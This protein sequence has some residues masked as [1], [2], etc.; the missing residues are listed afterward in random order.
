MKNPIIENLQDQVKNPK[1]QEYLH[2]VLSSF[3]NGNFRSSIVMLYSTVVCDII[4]KLTEMADIYGDAKA[5]DILQ[6][7]KDKQEEN[8]YS[9]DWENVLLDE[10]MKSHRVLEPSDYNNVDALK[11][12]R[13]LC[14][15]PVLKESNDLYQPNKAIV[16]GHILN[17]LENVLVKPSIVLQDLFHTFIED[18][19][20]KKSTLGTGDDMISY[21]TSQYLNK[22]NGPEY[23]YKIFKPLWKIVMKCADPEADDNREV[24]TNLLYCIYERNSQSFAAF[25]EN[26]KEYFGSNAGI[27]ENPTLLINFFNSHPEVY[28][29]MPQGAKITIS[30]AIKKNENFSDLAF[31][32]SDDIVSHIN[33]VKNPILKTAIYLVDV[34]SDIVN[35]TF[36]LDFCI[37]LYAES[38]DFDHADWFFDELIFPN[39]QEFSLVQMTH[40]LDECEHNGQVYGRK[41]FRSS[42]Y[43]LR[44]RIKELKPD[45][46]F[47]KYS[48]QEYYSK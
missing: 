10:C 32:L 37:R 48:I 44:A 2:E 24:N 6:K 25:I 19:A 40:L 39:L 38:Y 43:T 13:N 14:A 20:N 46:D 5:T 34:S 22:L 15:H 7:V 35:R 30:S 4:Y 17:M 8:L 47:S 3:Y 42:Y 18:V 41:K 9:P 16:Q 28:E 27:Q 36:A 1:T 29:M 12:L 26:D 11:K 33:S 21:V 45:F 23:E 31:F